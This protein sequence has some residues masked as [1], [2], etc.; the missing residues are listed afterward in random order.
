MEGQQLIEQRM[1][2]LSNPHM[3]PLLGM[4]AVTMSDNWKRFA[5]MASST[6]P[7]NFLEMWDRWYWFITDQWANRN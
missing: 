7:Q 2:M 5:D 1:L 4:T 6:S 3:G